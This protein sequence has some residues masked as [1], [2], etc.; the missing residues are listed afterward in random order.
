M[1]ELAIAEEDANGN[2]ILF[3][4]YQIAVD[5]KDNIYIAD[6]QDFTIKVFSSDGSFI[7]TIGRQ[8]EGPGEFQFIGSLAFFPDGRLLVLDF[9]ARRTSFFDSQGDFLNSYPWRN[10]HLR[11]YW[12]TED[13]F[14]VDERIYG[15]KSQLFIKTFDF[16]GNEILSI[17]EF[18]PIQPKILQGEEMSF[19]MSVPYT[20]YSILCADPNRK[21]LYH[22]MNDV[23]LIEVFDAGGD[24]IRKIIRPY[25][26]V[27]YTAEE[28]LE[29]KQRADERPDNPFS[30][31]IKDM[32]LPSIKTITESMLVDDRGNLWVGTFEEKEQ[33][34]RK[35]SAYDIFNPEGFYEARIW[36]DIHPR[37]FLNGKMYTLEIDEET[38]FQTAKRYHVVWEKKK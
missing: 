19:A 28:Q 6:R 25:S 20:P 21:L 38:G 24:L 34:N 7:R 4:P 9:R 31:M 1:E 27:P 37:I 36:T 2:I 11:F 33:E 26:P 32:E 18:S 29:F 14:T 15:E 3:K 10:S 22:C 16:S 35:L 17:G 23:Y 13:S 8:G 12:L 5:F 30:K